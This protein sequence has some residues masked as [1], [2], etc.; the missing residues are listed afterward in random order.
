MSDLLI[1]CGNSRDRRMSVGRDTWDNLVTMD[2]DPNCGADVV[3]DLEI[4]PWPF[5]DNEFDEVHAYC[6]LEHLGRQGDA[7]SFFRHFAEIYRILKPG[8]L[9]CGYSPSLDSRWLWGDPSHTRVISQESL[10]FLSQAAYAQVGST[11]MTDF[12]WLWKGDF[13]LYASDDNGDHYFFTLRAVK[14]ESHG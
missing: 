14:E 8:G 11:A 9:L 7:R 13:E 4:T 1:G 12:R 3:H 2:Y 10:T 5:A 6:V